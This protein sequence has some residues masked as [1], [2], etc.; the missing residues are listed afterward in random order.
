MWWGK[1]KG[2]QDDGK[3]KAVLF[4]DDDMPVRQYVHR[5]MEKKGYVAILCADG[6]EAVEAY[7]ERGAEIGL[8]ILDMIMPKMDGKETFFELKKID[9]DVKIVLASGY[10]V[11]ASVQ[12]CVKAGALGFLNKP[13]QLHELLETVE[14]YIRGN[15]A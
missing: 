6:T 10:S 9:P 14:Y 15:P 2:D 13:F 8:V 4:V 12:E 3:L 11:D 7:K 5:A 1:K